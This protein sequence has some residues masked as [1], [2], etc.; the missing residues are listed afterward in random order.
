M[1][2]R[3]A[4]A[5]SNNFTFEICGASSKFFYL[6]KWKNWQSLYIGNT[7]WNTKMSQGKKNDILEKV[8]NYCYNISNNNK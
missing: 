1:T 2:T 6:K 5:L 3:F 8:I 7:G 4:I